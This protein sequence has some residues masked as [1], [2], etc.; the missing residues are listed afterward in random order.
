MDK[1]LIK[2]IKKYLKKIGRLYSLFAIIPDS[3]YIRAKK[4]AAKED[5]ER[6]IKALNPVDLIFQNTTIL[7][8]ED[9]AYYRLTKYHK[10]CQIT[11]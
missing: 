1:T 4:E 2:E 6:G 8:T 10:V 3:L 5:K 9:I 7:V 11:K